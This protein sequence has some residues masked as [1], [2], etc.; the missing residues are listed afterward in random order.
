MD[1]D[2]TPQS[3]GLTGVP[4]IR[5][6][7]L[8]GGVYAI[9]MAILWGKGTHHSVH[10]YLCLLQSYSIQQSTNCAKRSPS[11]HFSE[12]DKHNNKSIRAG[13]HANED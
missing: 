5:K 3:K 1:P 4:L 11:G 8:K 12:K 10:L 2:I 6:S 13:Y 9:L 7:N